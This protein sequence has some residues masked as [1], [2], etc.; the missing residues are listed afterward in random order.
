[1]RRGCGGKGT[2]ERETQRK[3]RAEKGTECGRKG[4]EENKREKSKRNM[5]Y[6]RDTKKPTIMSYIAKMTLCD[7]YRW[8]T[9]TSSA[10]L[11]NKEGELKLSY[12]EQQWE[13]A[14]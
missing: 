7:I 9:A 2:I 1:M 11:N 10:Y 4:K 14:K 13:I 12:W 3:R 5:E 6:R 8:D